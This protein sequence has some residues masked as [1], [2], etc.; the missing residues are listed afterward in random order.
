M[1]GRAAKVLRKACGTVNA[2]RGAYRLVKREH[3]GMSHLRKGI[4]LAKAREMI[5]QKWL[6]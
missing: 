5:R 1:N 3:A 2:K 4:N 6:A